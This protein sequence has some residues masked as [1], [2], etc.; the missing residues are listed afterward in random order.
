LWNRLKDGDYAHYYADQRHAAKNV[1][2]QRAAI[3]IIRFYQ[4]A[5]SG[6]RGSREEFVEGL[7][8]LYQDIGTP[9]STR[10][11]SHLLARVIDE[12]KPR[13]HTSPEQSDFDSLEV[14]D[15]FGLAKLLRLI[16][17][18]D[19]QRSD[20]ASLQ[21]LADRAERLKLPYKRSR[22]DRL[23]NGTAPVKA[24]EFAL[25]AKLYN[26]KPFL[27]VHFLFPIFR[28]FVAVR[29]S[30]G[31]FRAVDESFVPG[32]ARYFVPCRRLAD[33]DI[34]IV[35]VELEGGEQTPE[36]R[37]PGHEL[38]IPLQG[39]I[40]VNFDVAVPIGA[41]LQSYAHYDATN[42]HSTANIGKGKARFLV[43]RFHE[44]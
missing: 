13:L 24:R 6:F 28:G 29:E 43:I 12:F 3:F 4:V 14:A 10:R 38:I 15:R 16:S 25:L 7:E 42:D 23:H 32:S 27:F 33:S 5:I 26:V 31:D 17:E 18:G 8:T 30:E 34:A 44:D 21:Q 35:L 19:T 36:N 40:A 41:P 1:G 39:E 11:A 20:G 37:H 9:R 22:I 2:D